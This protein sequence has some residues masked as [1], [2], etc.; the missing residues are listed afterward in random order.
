[1]LIERPSRRQSLFR[2]PQNSSTVTSPSSTVSSLGPMTPLRS[3]TPSSWDNL[4]HTSR[5]STPRLLSR[6]WRGNPLLDEGEPPPLTV[7]SKRLLVVH[8]Q[9]VYSSSSSSLYMPRPCRVPTRPSF[10]KHFF[11]SSESPLKGKG[12]ENEESRL[13][14][15]RSVPTTV[16][17]PVFNAPSF[18]NVILHSPNPRTPA[19]KS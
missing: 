10:L 13:L 15:G 5:K 14:A 9:K 7:T 2:I 1:M 18:T 4:V 8:G 11:T 6:P 12:F 16:S 3:D 19:T 17:A